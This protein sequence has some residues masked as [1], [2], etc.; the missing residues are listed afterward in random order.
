M[1][2]QGINDSHTNDKNSKP[3]RLINESSPYLLQHA[4]NPVDW[5][6]WGD[7]A[8]QRAIKEDKPIFISIGY[9]ACHWCHVMAHESFEDEGIARLMNEKFIN[10]KVDREERSDLD[11]IYQRV[12]QLATGNGGWPLSV[13]LTPDQKPFYVGTYFPKDSRYGMPGFGTILIQLSEAYKNRKQ[14]IQSATAEFMNALTNS[15][16]DIQF[17]Q[18]RQQDTVSKTGRSTLEEAAVALLHMADNVYGGF[19]QAPKFPNVSNLL[20]LL[21]YYDIS[22]VNR[23]KDFV[24]FTADKMIRGGIHDQLGG[25]FARYSTDQRWQVPHFEKMLYDNALLT[26]LYAE[27]YQL[28]RNKSYL[29]TAEKTLDYVIREMTSPNG[30]FYSA[31]D[32]DSEGEEGKFYT[33]SKQEIISSLDDEKKNADIF[34][35]YYGVTEG[36]NFEGKNILHITKSTGEIARKYGQTPEEIEQVLQHISKRLF[37]IREKRTKPGR[38]DK[39]LTSWNGLMISAFSKVY[40]ITNNPTYLSHATKGIEFIEN[41]IGTSDGR[42]RRTFKDGVSKLNAYL[43]DYAFY[44]NAL[45]DVFEVDTNSRYIEKAILYAD[46]MIRHFWDEK[47]GNFFFT[48]DDHEQ[49]IVRTKSLYDLAIPSGNSMAAS[50]L[51]RLYHITRNSNYLLKAEQIMSA[52]AK[53]AAENPFGFGQLLNAIYLYIRKPIEITIIGTNMKKPKD[54]EQMSNWLGRQFFPNSIIALVKD[55]SQLDGLNKYPFFDG[56][57]VENN[58]LTKEISADNGPLNSEHAFVCKNF[59]CSLPIHSLEQLQKSLGKDNDRNGL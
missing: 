26:Q 38:D 55:R 34:C 4:H 25:G 14:E 19:G 59:S 43:D 27:L 52:G 45:L 10:I 41:K 47:Q 21:R 28:S 57:K 33:W 17:S 58:I 15:V 46:S 24:M 54:L 36:G 53:A 48:S 49:L 5:Y 50:T 16:Q 8:L 35:E 44:I 37:T 18:E 7:E 6:A 3:N 23:F 51:L 40:R 13:F 9:S 31:Q 1:Q 30:G 2:E 56:K 11:D 32:A 22:G 12:A 20:F 42:L 29:E 39:I